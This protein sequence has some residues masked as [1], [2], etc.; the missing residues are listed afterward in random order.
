M[1]ATQR[2]DSVTGIDGLWGATLG[3]RAARLLTLTAVLVSCIAA[4]D[5][6]SALAAESSPGCVTELPAPVPRNLGRRPTGVI[7]VNF[8]DGTGPPVAAAVLGE[9]SLISGVQLAVKWSTLEPNEGEFKFAGLETLFEEAAASGQYVVLTL[10][11][12]FHSPEWALKG[13]QKVKSSWSYKEPIKKND[14]QVKAKFLPVPWNHLYLCRWFG[15]LKAVAAKFAGNSSLRMIDLAGPNSVSTEMSLPDWTGKGTPLYN[16][17]EG[18]LYEEGRSPK[19][20]HGSD[21]RMW[22][23]LGYTPD[24]YVDAWKSVFQAY[25]DL[26]PD[27]YLSLNLIDGLPIGNNKRIDGGEITSS[28]L[29]VIAAGKRLEPGFV[30][31]TDGLN[32]STGSAAP[33]PYVAGN[34]ADAVTGNQ[35]PVPAKLGPLTSEDLHPALTDG[36]DFVE[37]YQEQVLEGLESRIRPSL[38]EPT[39]KQDAET[40][41]AM[42]EAA[43]RLPDTAGCASLTLT[44]TPASATLGTPVTVT[45]RAPT[46]LLSGLDFKDNAYAEP[47]GVFSFSPVIGIYEDDKLIKQCDGKAATVCEVTVASGPRITN[48]TA[49]VGV[50]RQRGATLIGPAPK[51]LSPL[52]IISSSAQVV[53]TKAPP[54]INVGEGPVTPTP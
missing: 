3:A 27:Q 32:P 23:A 28:T 44:A 38:G 31:Q 6:G 53:R 46:N 54:P 43:E 30:L 16:Y 11:P 8:W 47:F 10:L 7:S 21:I 34:C 13:V 4:F 12:G 2:V 39:G 14:H 5:V 42:R 48:F 51:P 37:L 45:A 49:D 26:F 36:D 15:F 29:R 25:R 17:D 40:Y 1:S 18:L 22:K 19:T 24:R 33:D 52:A 35:T 50:L 41:E 9:P 20:F